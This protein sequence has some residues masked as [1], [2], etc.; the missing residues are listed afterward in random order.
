MTQSID[1]AITAAPPLKPLRSSVT[2]A[3][4]SENNPELAPKTLDQAKTELSQ[5]TPDKPKESRPQSDNSAHSQDLLGDADKKSSP[6]KI[7][8]VNGF[9]TAA[10]KAKKFIPGKIVSEDDNTEDENGNSPKAP[11]RKIKKKTAEIGTQTEPIRS[12]GSCV[13]CCTCRK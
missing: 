11:S 7:L 1:E 6:E 2:S 9:D 8:K 12:S 3:P 13:C 10:K 5:K 4:K